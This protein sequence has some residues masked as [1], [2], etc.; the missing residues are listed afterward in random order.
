M[1]L[2]QDFTSSLIDSEA[3]RQ[4]KKIADREL[5]DEAKKYG[6]I[7]GTERN[8]LLGAFADAVRSV[9][10]YAQTPDPTMPMGKANPA[11]GLLS[12][13]IGLPGT[14]KTLDELSYGNYG[15]LGTGKGMTWKPKDDTVDAAMTLVPLGVSAGKSAIDGGVKLAQ[16]ATPA[17][18]RAVAKTMQEGG[19]GA[20]LLSDLAYGS[21]SHIVSNPK[22]TYPQEKALL[23]A[24][25]NAAKP[26]S[27][28]GLGLR[29]D[30]TPQER[31]AAMGFDIEFN[32]GT[33][34][35]D[36]LLEKKA[37][38]PKRATSGPMPYGTND[39]AIASNYAASKADTSRVADDSGDIRNYFQ[40]A[41][42]DIGISGRSP[43]SVEQSWHFLPQEQKQQI[44]ANAKRVGYENLDEA[45][46]P[47]TLHPEGVDATLS[48]DHFDYLMRQHRNNPLSALREMWHDGG[49][50][51]NSPEELADI[52]K[53]AGYK[54][55]ISQSNAPWFS[56]NGVFSGK[57]RMDS[58]IDTSNADEL[59]SKV[60]PALKDAFKGDRTRLK[61]YGADMWDKN[62]R[63]TPKQWVDELEKDVGSGANSS[64]WTTIPDKVT[65]QLKALGYDGILDTGGKMG[66]VGHQVAI[67]FAPNQVRS[68][69]AAFDPLRKHEADLLA[70]AMPFG[71]LADPENRSRLGQ[72]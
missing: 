64:V 27:Q 3:A 28:G 22:F 14:A 37:F 60:I 55:P 69:F 21:K 50:L 1:G 72:Q 35:L 54:A 29:P 12:N 66:G 25:K 9:N 23:T 15:A 24:Q 65:D 59:T 58:P 57:A 10:D 43:L 61:P 32:H 70:G 11:L 39:T 18:E 51:V 17:I 63:F 42:K 40:V 7:S 52:Y 6:S 38:D 36:R 13:F 4:R 62:T 49:D 19:T 44:L 53:L 47:F 41:P 34:R 67:P 30:N 2:L 26:V 31:A 46:G 45:T 68:N 56:A 5:A 16:K 33:Q 8:K 71:L 48:S 20:G